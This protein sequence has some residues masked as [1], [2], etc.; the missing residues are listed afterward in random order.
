MDNHN[1]NASILL[2]I[3][4]IAEIKLKK[5]GVASYKTYLK[6]IIEDYKLQKNDLFEILSLYK[7]KEAQTI[8]KLLAKYDKG[9]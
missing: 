7:N 4:W 8:L 2:K 3:I 9:E 1:L 6:Q 5:E